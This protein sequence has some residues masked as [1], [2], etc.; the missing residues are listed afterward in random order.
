MSRPF[1]VETPRISRTPLSTLSRFSARQTLERPF[2]TRHRSTCTTT[3]PPHISS[4][5]S[6]ESELT[7]SSK[8]CTT[9]RL[10]RLLKF[11]HS[12]LHSSF[13]FIILMRLSLRLLLIFQEALRIAMN[14]QLGGSASLAEMHSK[15]A[16][17]YYRRIHGERSA[18]IRFAI[19]HHDRALKLLGETKYKSVLAAEKIQTGITFYHCPDDFFT[20]ATETERRE[21]L[22]GAAALISTGLSEINIDEQMIMD[23]KGHRYLG[24]VFLALKRYDEA[25]TSFTTV[26]SILATSRCIL[27]E[28]D[29]WV[30]ARFFLN[31][32][33]PVVTGLLASSVATGRTLDAI[34][35]L[36]HART[37]YLFEHAIFKFPRLQLID[38]EEQDVPR[39]LAEVQAALNQY[40]DDPEIELE[41]QRQMGGSLV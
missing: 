16:L 6:T 31:N 20:D 24:Q 37:A 30:K 8:P 29:L 36:E 14:T 21:H 12:S 2:W 4:A 23:L 35:F 22:E 10:L 26:A 40:Y 3:W 27:P 25:L 19:E 5:L 34:V 15:V 39:R 18:N 38:M 11:F 33:V 9:T 7:I 13:S 1:R 28:F 41:T 32:N 17:C